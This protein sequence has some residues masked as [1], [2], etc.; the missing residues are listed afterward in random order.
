MKIMLF[1]ICD[2]R[3]NQ[4]GEGRPLG[5]KWHYLYWCTVQPY[6]VLRVQKK[7]IRKVYILREGFQN[8]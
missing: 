7:H 4:Q 8:L 5:H 6:A 1:S 2:F 3:E